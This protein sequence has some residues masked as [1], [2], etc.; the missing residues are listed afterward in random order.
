MLEHSYA[1][2]YRRGLAVMST[3]LDLDDV[4]AQS[5]LALA[6]LTALRER[7]KTA[8]QRTL[9]LVNVLRR[10]GYWA[11]LMTDEEVIA[12]LDAALDAAIARHEP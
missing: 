12:A 9:H 6:E 7:V 3:Q 1:T 2:S 5:P 8:E 10:D 4:A 11:A